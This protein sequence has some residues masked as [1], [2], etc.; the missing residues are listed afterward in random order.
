MGTLLLG[1]YTPKERLGFKEMLAA[2][3]SMP[4]EN[5]AHKAPGQ[6]T[7]ALL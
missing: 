4:K 1:Q 2:R 5:R 3:I 7:K 6:L